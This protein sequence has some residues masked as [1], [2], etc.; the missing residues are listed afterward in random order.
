MNTG[1]LFLG[2]LAGVAVG[3]V[4]GILFAPDKGSETREKISKKSED[5]TESVKGK[6]DEIL[7]SISKK[8]EKVKEEVTA[9]A[10]KEKTVSA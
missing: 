9:E 6:F 10:E 5:F 2:A 3:A 1:K 4:L 8:F 7:D